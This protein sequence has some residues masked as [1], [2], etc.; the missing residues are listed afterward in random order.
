MKNW[1]SWNIIEDL[2]TKVGYR[3]ARLGENGIFQQVDMLARGV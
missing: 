3:M 1:I 2:V